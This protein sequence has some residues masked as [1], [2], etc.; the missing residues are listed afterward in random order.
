MNR[1]VYLCVFGREDYRFLAALL[2]VSILDHNRPAGFHVLIHCDA[3]FEDFLR[4]LLR[5]LGVDGT[6]VAAKD[7]S[8]NGTFAA[9]A[10]YDLFR[11]FDPQ[12]YEAILYLDTDI[13]VTGDLSPVFERLAARPERP[14]VAFNEYGETLGRRDHPFYGYHLFREAGLLDAWRDAAVFSSGVLCFRPTEEVRALFDD[15]KALRDETQAGALGQVAGHQ[16][17]Q[18]YMNFLG[19]T[20]G[21]V[22]ADGLD[23]LVANNPDAAAPR[24]PLIAHFPGS[25]GNPDKILKV[26]DLVLA[27]SD[28]SPA[29]RAYAASLRE[30]LR[31]EARPV[32]LPPGPAFGALKRAANDLVYQRLT[33]RHGFAVRHGPF[34]RAGMEYKVEGASWGDPVL[35][36]LGLYESGLHPVIEAVA[37]RTGI[38]AVIDVGCAE[39]YYAAGLGRL[40]GVPRIHAFDTNLRTHRICEGLVRANCPAAGL[41]MGG[42]IGPDE[43]DALLARGRSVVFMDCEGDERNLLRLD[44]VPHLRTTEVIV[45]CHEFI[46]GYRGIVDELIA[47]FRDTHRPAIVVERDIAASDVPEIRALSGMHRSLVTSE[48]RFEPMRWLHLEPLSR[49]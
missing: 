24:L 23:G 38:E 48:T 11:I 26:R 17:D 45:E 4:D 46:R 19:L 30:T 25:V 41:S 27:R 33:A 20:R 2:L 22:E 47:E 16:F 49:D 29:L 28:V 40:L 7:A 44:A 43:L 36:W 34:A 12:P 1:L 42:R 13:L 37:T 39:G 32:Q 3:R 8:R 10:R 35:K 6:V 21:L 31:L 18:P 5:D 15:M 14:V 9:W